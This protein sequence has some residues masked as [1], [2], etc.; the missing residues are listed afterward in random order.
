MAYP[1]THIN[2][3]FPLWKGMA[4]WHVQDMT[5]HPKGMTQ[6]TKNIITQKSNP[7]FFLLLHE[8]G[9]RY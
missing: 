6:K 3:T 5:R 7:N 4:G 8:K 9:L 2:T 1:A